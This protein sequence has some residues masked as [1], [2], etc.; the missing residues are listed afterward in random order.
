MIDLEK[1]QADLHAFAASQGWKI[2]SSTSNRHGT[3]VALIK[4]LASIGA[5]STCGQPIYT[6]DYASLGLSMVICA[7]C[8]REQER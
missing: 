6:P 1:A 8:Y 3:I 7:A 2:N 4:P 5:C